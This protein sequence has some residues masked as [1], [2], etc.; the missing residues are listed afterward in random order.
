MRPEGAEIGANG[1]VVEEV[2]SSE[3]RGAKGK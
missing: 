1:V 2:G 3:E